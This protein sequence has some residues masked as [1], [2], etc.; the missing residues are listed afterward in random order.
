M[1]RFLKDRSKA[2]G[3]A[4]GS[5][6][7]IGR[8][9]MDK[10]IIQVMKF[11]KDELVEKEVASIKDAR[12]E[13]KKDAVTWINIYGI[14]D[15]EMIQDLGTEFN[16]PALL[17][18][19]ILNTDQPPKYENGETYDAFIIKMLQAEEKSNRIH[20]EQ[21]SIVL[22]EN[23]VLTL[24]ERVGDFFNPV[25]ERIRK[26]KG[27]LRHNGNDYLAYALMDTIVDYY[28][29]LIESIGSK[30]EEMEDRLFRNMDSG[31]VEEI[32]RFKT[33]LNYL[34]KSIRP[35]REFLLMLNKEEDSFIQEKNQQFLRDLFDLVAQCTDTLELYNN[36]LSDQLNIYNTNMSNKMNEVMKTLT[37][38][39]SVFIPLTFVAGIYGMNFEHMP[40]LGYKYSYLIFWIAIL[41]LGGGLFIYFKRK[42]W[43]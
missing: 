20:A 5:L 9:K 35:V 27:R 17:L 14:H 34:R 13:F 8:Q 24:Q 18:E 11:D 33:E 36:M 42:K 15:L 21:I 4:P 32:Y 22:G 31:M 43:L 30:I 1:A 23:Y 6:I 12:T 10:P 37:I 25:R 39:A 41:I 26:G 16:L 38:F 7:L 2:K 19:D 3:T 28:T 40:E 29:G